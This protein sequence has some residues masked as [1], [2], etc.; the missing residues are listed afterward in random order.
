MVITGPRA[1]YR[2][3]L[4]GALCTSQ[5]PFRLTSSAWAHKIAEVLKRDTVDIG[6]LIAGSGQ[7]LT[8]DDSVALEP[9]EGIVFPE[10]ARVVLELRCVDRML[11]ITGTIDV[12]ARGACDRCLEEVERSMHLDVEERFDPGADSQDDPFGES[13]VLTGTRLDVADLVQQVVLSA[14]PMGLLCKNDCA[15]LCGTC[16]QNL[17]ASVCSHL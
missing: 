3:R 6:G 13:N 16:G 14:V 12:K 2:I 10:P 9:F 17:N 11:E 7:R 15:G 4:I 8:I 1:R 5:L